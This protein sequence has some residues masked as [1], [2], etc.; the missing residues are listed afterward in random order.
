MSQSRP[1]LLSHTP[2]SVMN[3]VIQQILERYFEVKEYCNDQQYDPVSTLVVAPMRDAE[4]WTHR[5]HKQGFRIVIDNLWEA[6]DRYQ[7]FQC[8]QQW[9][10]ARTHIMQTPNWFWYFESLSLAAQRFQYTPA[11]TYQHLALMPMRRETHHRTRLYDAM[12]PWLH[13]CYWSYLAKEHHYLPND[14]DINDASAQRYVNIDWYNHTCFSVVA[15]T[16]DDNVIYQQFDELSMRYQGP[17]P[18]VTEKTFKPIQ[19]QHPFMVYGQRN[20]LKFLHDLGFETFENL[21]DESY[22]TVRSSHPNVP[23]DN[24]LKI[25]MNNIKNFEKKPRDLLTQQKIQ[26]NHNHFNNMSLVE[27]RVIK[28]IIDPLLEFLQ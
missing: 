24:K 25:I 12:Q 27:S 3:P 17:W 23:Q 14:Q 6:T 28:E 9:D 11:P 26:H 19:Y 4:E 5:L 2:T 7:A 21:F 22:D 10:V 1:V 15:E 18:F 8:N 13:D 20:I 16:Y